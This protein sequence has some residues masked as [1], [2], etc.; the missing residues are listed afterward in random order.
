MRFR[1]QSACCDRRQTFAIGFGHINDP[2][3]E[4]L[5]DMWRSDYEQSEADRVSSASRANN[6]LALISIVTAA[7]T[8]IVGSVVD[9]HPVLVAV[10]LSIG[11]VLL[12]AAFATVVL[13]IRAQQVSQWDAPRIDPASASSKRAL[14]L[15][16]AIEFHSA[17]RQNSYR[18]NN[19]FGYLRDA[20][21][22]ALIAVTMLVLLAPT[23]VLAEM[24]KSSSREGDQTP[25]PS[26][27]I[28]DP[29]VEPPASGV[30]RVSRSGCR[31]SALAVGEEG[32]VINSKSLGEL[33]LKEVIPNE[34]S[35]ESQEGHRLFIR[36]V[37]G[38]LSI[39]GHH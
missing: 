14:T 16:C 27:P 15:M 37:E 34:T 3:L 11:S 19:V 4:R 33:T 10:A 28:A 17:A 5:A 1:I 23:A 25:H 21:R 29:S 18:L 30:L 38:S 12:V 7:T 6:L 8:L 32:W 22:W 24:L 26:P 35:D 39:A 36:D 13:A 9:T 20:Q 2:E 31:G